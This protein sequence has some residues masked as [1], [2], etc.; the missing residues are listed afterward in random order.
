MSPRTTISNWGNFP[1]ILTTVEQGK[2][3]EQ[4]EKDA[5]HDIIETFEYGECH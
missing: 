1:K 5:L 4:I 2:D 3:V